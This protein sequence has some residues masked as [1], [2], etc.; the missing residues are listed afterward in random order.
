MREATVN[1]HTKEECHK[2]YNPQFDEADDTFCAV[3]MGGGINSCQVSK[4][5]ENNLKVNYRN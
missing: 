1:I 2:V 5:F 3:H 4:S